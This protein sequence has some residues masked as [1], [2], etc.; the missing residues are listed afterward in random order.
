[1]PSFTD[2]LGREWTIEITLVEIKQ[3]RM[4]LNLDLLSVFEKDSQL[5]NRLANDPILL[6]DALSVV[7]SDAIKSR[8]L[9]DTAFA[10]GL[11]GDGLQAAV[12]CFVEAIA[13]FSR[14]H[15]RGLI[16]SL[17]ERNRQLETSA[18]QRME[19]ALPD[20][21]AAAEAQIDSTLAKLKD[22]FTNSPES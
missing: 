4:V 18:S 13:V 6:V 16:R 22:S 1:M 21:V 12:D 19:A 15:Q 2:A 17:W 20:V 7:L 11:I 5:L 14:P 10:R 9:D 3:L 8:G